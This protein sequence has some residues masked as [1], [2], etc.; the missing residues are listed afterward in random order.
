MNLFR[1]GNFS[2][3][4]YADDPTVVQGKIWRGII[5]RVNLN[6]GVSGGV[7]K[8]NNGDVI[9]GI[10]NLDTFWLRD[11]LTSGHEFL[12]AMNMWH[13][14]WDF[15]LMNPASDRT[16]SGSF[17]LGLHGVS[18]FQLFYKVGE[19]KRQTGARY[20]LPEAH[21]GERAILLNLPLEEIY[22]P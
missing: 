15:G 10:V 14:S 18:L 6:I 13:E 16:Q 9:S 3:T 11:S 17:K 5:V 22:Y 12:H 21:Q 4:G 8:T 7:Q 1:L 2:E 20:G 19:V